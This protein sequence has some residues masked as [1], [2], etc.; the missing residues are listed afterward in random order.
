MKRFR[1][2]HRTYYNF[3][4]E[5]SL[6]EHLLRL[7]PREGHDL[8][9]ES[10]SLQIDPL[11]VLRWYRDPGDNVVAV[12]SF[13][14][15]TRQLSI[16]SDVVVEQ[17]QL[18]D[19]PDTAPGLCWPAPYAATDAAWLRPYVGRGPV[20]RNDALGTWLAPVNA[21]PG[22]PVED[23]LDQLADRIHAGMTYTLRLEPGVQ[24]PELTLALRSGACRDF[25]ALFV[26]AARRLGLAARFV[27]GYLRSDAVPADY[28]ATH[29]WA[30]VFLSGHG[31]RGY[32]PTL[33]ARVGSDHIAVAT[34][35]MAGDLPP[36][37]GSF[38]GPAT[39]VMDVGVWVTAM[40]ERA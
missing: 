21:G 26:E 18:E 19:L 30:E 24:P 11:P 7:R 12:A 40:T 29:A 20:D 6:G 2:L 10:S 17:Y 1:I 36:V 16:V 39:S 25:A 15:L 5:V 8:R 23:A 35:P 4:A 31:W 34:S 38:A 27:S 28:G 13:A 37:A 22:T 3:S 32:D 9:I 14:G 33:G